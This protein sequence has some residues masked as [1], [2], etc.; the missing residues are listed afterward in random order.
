MLA[1]IGGGTVLLHAHLAPA[2]VAPMLFAA[3]ALACGIVFFLRLQRRGKVGAFVRRLAG[4]RR[5]WQTFAE[6]A[7]VMDDTLRTFYRDRKADFIRVMAWHMAGFAMGIAQVA[8]FL[9]QV[10]RHAG[11][12]AIAGI[13]TLGLWFDL[14]A[15]AVPMGL[16]TL[17]GSRILAFAA[18]GFRALDGLAFGI[19]LRIGQTLLAVA[20]LGATLLFTAKI[21]QR[22]HAFR[23]P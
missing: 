19:A 5:R 12:A 8:W 14:L 7:A 2:A 10:D 22:R 1:T 23:E 4:G 20:G 9:A 3:G 6:Q 11:L 13:W 21:E 18:F 16:G 15:F 17:E